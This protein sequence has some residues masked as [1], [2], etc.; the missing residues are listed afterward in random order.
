M[1]RPPL[2]LVLVSVAL[3][4]A[5]CGTPVGGNVTT[6][7]T[8]TVTTTA[9]GTPPT[10]GGTPSATQPRTTMV[11]S[12]TPPVEATAYPPGVGPDGLTNLSALERAHRQSLTD[13]RGAAVATWNVTSAAGQ[14]SRYVRA[15]ADSGGVPALFVEREREN[16]TVTDSTARWANET[17]SLSRFVRDGSTTY[18]HQLNPDPLDPTSDRAGLFTLL[19]DGTFDQ[20]SVDGPPGAR[21]YTLTATSGELDDRRAEHATL[22]E[23]RG[24]V[25]VDG[26][27]T[28]RRANVTATL[29]HERGQR[30]VRTGY[31]LD[32]GDGVTVDRPAWVRERVGRV[33]DTSITATKI[34]ERFVR[35]E[36]TGR[37]TIDAGSELLVWYAGCGRAQG[38]L[39]EPFRPSETLYVYVSNETGDLAVNRT[40]PGG[41][42]RPFDDPYSLRVYP[43]GQLGEVDAIADA[44][45]ETRTNATVDESGASGAALPVSA[46]VARSAAGC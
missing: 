6:A 17:V 25:V 22:R 37:A 18:Q 28:I 34:N 42:A 35:V 21:R 15:S 7:E 41:P 26:D 44:N 24:T 46:G 33:L 10:P 8:T 36:H 3:V 14:R 30:T 45:V 20:V 23:Y 1:R 29:E 31:E 27:G 32:T 4:L 43:P 39:G 2:H 11:G 19:G 38:E 16:G 5:G 9:T 40:A 13:R 12:G